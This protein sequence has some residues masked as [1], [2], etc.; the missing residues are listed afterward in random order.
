M[1]NPVKVMRGDPV[2]MP[3]A[4]CQWFAQVVRFLFARPDTA[5]PTLI[6]FTAWLLRTCVSITSTSLLYSRLVPVPAGLAWR[7][8]GTIGSQIAALENLP[9]SRVWGDT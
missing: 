5:S 4:F 9:I 8:A 1:A 2:V 3:L 6:S 7:P